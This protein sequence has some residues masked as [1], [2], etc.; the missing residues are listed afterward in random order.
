MKLIELFNKPEKWNKSWFALDVNGE[1]CSPYSEKAVSYCIIGGIKKCYP[2]NK[3]AIERSMKD[4][5]EK[6]GYI[7]LTDWNDNPKT[8]FEDLRRIITKLNI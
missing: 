3:M 6:V 1:E 4:E 7:Y 2:D 5:L 8:T